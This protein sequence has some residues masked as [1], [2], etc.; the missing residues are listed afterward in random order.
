[1]IKITLL[2]CSLVLL[3]SCATTATEFQSAK[4]LSEDAMEITPSYS[5]TLFDHEVGVELGYGVS[6][7]VEVRG[8]AHTFFASHGDGTDD[9]FINYESP[10]NVFIKSGI[11][12]S[13]LEDNISF[14]LPISF[15]V[16]GVQETFSLQPSLLLSTELFSYL[17]VNLALKEM[18]YI[19]TG[20]YINIHS[21]NLG[22]GFPVGDAVVIRPIWNL[23]YYYSKDDRNDGDFM[24]K[25]G[26]GATI[27]L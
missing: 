22:F 23:M 20:P 3:V 10:A 21:A 4:V 18:M 5:T 19:S 13:I 16:F 17:E 25:V 9:S 12:Y 7:N 1:M 24:M 26:L 2:L 27:Q 8:G 11:K 6:E 14:Y 15:D